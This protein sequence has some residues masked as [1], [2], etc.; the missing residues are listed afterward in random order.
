MAGPVEESIRRK[1]SENLSPVS[2]QIYN[3]SPKHRGHAGVAGD[4]SGET[5]FSVH[6]VSEKFN[7]KGL[8]K[9]HQMIYQLLDEELKAGLHALSIN[10]KTP[11]E[12]TS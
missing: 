6:V 8:V 5:H 3:D 7:G 12:E 9:R 1:I 10:T 11:A 2:L 4:Q